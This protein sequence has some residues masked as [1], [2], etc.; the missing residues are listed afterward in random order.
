M[1]PLYIYC[2][3]NG[4]IVWIWDPK[5]FCDTQIP[6]KSSAVRDPQVVERDV[7]LE[8]AG[9]ALIQMEVLYCEF[10]NSAQEASELEQDTTEDRKAYVNGLNGEIFFVAPPYESKC[11]DDINLVIRHEAC[12]SFGGTRVD[13]T[14]LF[15]VLNYER[16]RSRSQQ[17][18]PSQAG[19]KKHRESLA[20][21]SA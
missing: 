11:N 8:R 18:E 20:G 19:Q 6:D 2:L 17:S 12:P 5:S 7:R 10:E 9:C 15:K 21:G 13:V 14:E 3:V 1:I 16:K 4:Y